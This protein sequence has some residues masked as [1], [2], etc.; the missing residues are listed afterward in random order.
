[1]GNSWVADYTWKDKSFGKTVKVVSHVSTKS[2]YF[3][4]A[5]SPEWLKLWDTR[6]LSFHLANAWQLIY[7]FFCAIGSTTIGQWS[8]KTL[9][10]GIHLI[11]CW[12][13]LVQDAQTPHYVYW[14]QFIYYGGTSRY[15]IIS[16]IF[17]T[18]KIFKS[19]KR[20]L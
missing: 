5:G 18:N 20:D 16:T 10:N 9:S 13:E 14:L 6:C 7:R 19:K 8:F 2:F 12:R 1:M 17:V 11:K 3:T 15:R 4:P